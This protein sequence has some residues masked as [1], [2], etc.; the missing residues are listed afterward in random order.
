MTP[1]GKGNVQRH[2]WLRTVQPRARLVIQL[3][4]MMHEHEMIYAQ[5]L[6]VLATPHP[7]PHTHTT[8]PLPLHPCHVTNWRLGANRFTR[9]GL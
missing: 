7:P 6:Q 2:F 3:A 4:V 8:V 5:E 9:A 1:G